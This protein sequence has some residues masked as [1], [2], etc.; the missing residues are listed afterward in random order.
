MSAPEKIAIDGLK[1][2]RSKDYEKLIYR[3]NLSSEEISD[4]LD[5]NHQKSN[6]QKGQ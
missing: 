6:T 3:K 4:F 1:A 2:K 5:S